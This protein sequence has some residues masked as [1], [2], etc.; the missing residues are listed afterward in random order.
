MKRFQQLNVRE[1][2]LV[3]ELKRMKNVPFF[4]A[5]ASVTDNFSEASGREI[6]ALR[7]KLLNIN[8]RIGNMSFGIANMAEIL[9]GENYSAS[10]LLSMSDDDLAELI[11]SCNCW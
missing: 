8:S 10:E 5:L 4:L 1:K 2:I 6:I 9:S 7:D 11:L 3:Y